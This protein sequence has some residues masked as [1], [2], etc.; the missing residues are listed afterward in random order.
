MMATPR[1]KL[2]AAIVDTLCE[3]IAE[4][5]SARAMCKIVGISQKTLWNWLAKDE[6]FVQQYARAKDRC[7]DHLAEEILEISDSSERDKYTDENGRE[8]VDHENINRSRLRVDARKWYASKLA[9]KKYGD[10]VLNQH[11]G[12]DPANPI[13][14][15]ITV[16][17]IAA[18][19]DK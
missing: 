16:S 8:V 4:G 7:A 17:F 1:V 10:K 9:P 11:E 15:H 19:P 14:Q 2:T 18:N 6:T 5:K 12:G 3:G 13:Q